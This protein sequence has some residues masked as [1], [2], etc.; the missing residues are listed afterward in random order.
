MPTVGPAPA[1]GHAGHATG[2]EPP[3]AGVRAIRAAFATPSL[4]AAA[5]GDVMAVPA[6]AL[7]LALGGASVA[8]DLGA[9]Q[10]PPRTRAVPPLAAATMALEDL[11]R[12]V[13]RLDI[14]HG[15]RPSVWGSLGVAWMAEGPPADDGAVQPASSVAPR[16]AILAKV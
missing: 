7:L 6:D 15:G 10:V 5:G 16:R 1:T 12:I 8:S 11:G 2:P 4:L 14:S 9:A 13:A 3:G